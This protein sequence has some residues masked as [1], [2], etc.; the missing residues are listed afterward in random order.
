MGPGW[1]MS[2]QGGA[3]TEP[4]LGGRVAA[5]TVS[6]TDP[7]PDACLTVDYLFDGVRWRVLDRDVTLW[8]STPEASYG[9]FG[10]PGGPWCIP[11]GDA[12]GDPLRE[13]AAVYP[14]RVPTGVE[15]LEAVHAVSSGFDLP[16]PPLVRHVGDAA[17]GRRARVHAGPGITVTVD[18]ESGM[19][20]GYDLVNDAGY[21]YAATTTRFELVEPDPSQFV[22]AGPVRVLSG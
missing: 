11:Q 18:E 16:E 5:A 1:T 19:V 13:P 12:S 2:D 14:H 8:L 20:L 22:H 7:D 17:T 9:D 10:H 21:R 6:F 3:V 15:D 4:H